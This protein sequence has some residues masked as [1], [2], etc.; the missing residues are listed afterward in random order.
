MRKLIALLDTTATLATATITLGASP[1]AA[2]VPI[3]GAGSTWSQIAVD[4]WRAEV[5]R[6]GLSINYQGQGST[7][8][9]TLYYQDQVDFAVSEIPFQDGSDGGGIDER[10]EAKR[11]PYAYLPIV[12]GGTAFMSHLNIGGRMITDLRLSPD[13][14]AKIFTGVIKSWDDPAVTADN[15]GRKFPPL[16][17]KVAR[18][19]VALP[20]A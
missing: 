11:R 6:F 7:A 10:E 12:A 13:T 9:R 18:P 16:P 20:V 5:N 3:T 15:A 1:A 14:V 2:E 17:I 8:G 4:Q 19:L